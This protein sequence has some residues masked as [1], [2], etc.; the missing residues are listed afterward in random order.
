MFALSAK[1][2]IPPGEV[3]LLQLNKGDWKAGAG[4]RAGRIRHALVFQRAEHDADGILSQAH[5]PE[6]GKT[7]P[8]IVY[9]S[10]TLDVSPFSL[11]DLPLGRESKYQAQAQLVQIDAADEPMITPYLSWAT[12]LPIAT[13]VEQVEAA[14][15]T[16]VDNAAVENFSVE[17]AM[18]FL[19]S[20]FPEAQITRMPHNNPGFD[21]LVTVAGRVLRYVEVKGTR[22]DAPVFFMTETERTFSRDNNSLYTLIVAWKIDLEAGTCLLND[23]DGEVPVGSIIRADRYTGRLDVTASATRNGAT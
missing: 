14:A 22:S 8:W 15:S 23:R 18:K 20:L 17:H 12:A 10:A 19:G 5:W 21:V 11:E 6:A 7:W 1:P 3:L 4:D 13:S 2:R 16:A 9:A